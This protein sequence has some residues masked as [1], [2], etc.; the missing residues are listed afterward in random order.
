[1][2]DH[3]KL[4]SVETLRS[5]ELC[6]TESIYNEDQFTKRSPQRI[7]MYLCVKNA[8]HICFNVNKKSFT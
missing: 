3:A 2:K 6:L 7:L 1:M 5:S 4:N 8:V